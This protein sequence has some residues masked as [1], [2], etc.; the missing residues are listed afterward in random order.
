MA[1]VAHPS[2][3]QDRIAP[4]RPAA[5]TKTIDAVTKAPA[6]PGLLLRAFNAIIEGRR[7]QMQPEIDRYVAWHG[8]NFTDSLERDISARMLSGEWNLRR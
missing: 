4:Y 8:R 5:G 1:Y 2:D 7:R 3:F 6:R